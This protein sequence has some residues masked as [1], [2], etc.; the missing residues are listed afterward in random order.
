MRNVTLVVPPILSVARPSLGISAMKSALADVDCQTTVLYAALKYAELLGADINQQ[1][2]EQ[3]DHRLLV[4]DWIFSQC[5]ATAYHAERDDHYLSHVLAPKISPRLLDL[6]IAA[7]AQAMDFVNSSAQDICASQPRIVGI[8]S[9]FQQHCAALA[10]AKA[11]KRLKPDVTIC[12]GG[13]NCED[14]MGRATLDNFPYVDFVFSGES[15]RSFPKFVKDFFSRGHEPPADSRQ[16]RL[17]EPGYADPL[18]DLDELHIPDFSDYFEALRLASFGGRVNPALTFEASRGCWWGAKHH[19][20]FC[21]LNGGTMAFR[22][23]SSRR[24]LS[25]IE[26]LSTRWSVNAFSPSDNILAPRHIDEVFGQMPSDSELRFFYE[27][28]SNMS[29]EQILKIAK[30][31]VTWLQPGIESLCDHVLKL[32]NKGV[33]R[34]LNLRFLRSCLEIGVVPLWN[35]LVG[36]PGEQDWEYEEVTKLIPYIEHLNPPQNGPSFLRVD[37]FSPYFTQRAAV[38]FDSMRP[39]E[40][41]A[42]VYDLPPDQVERIAYFFAGQS[43]K[44]ISQPVHAQLAAAIVKWRERFWNQDNPPILASVPLGDSLLV[45][46]TRSIASVETALLSPVE[47][48]ILTNARSP[49]KLQTLIAK[50]GASSEIEKLL[51]LGYLIK[52]ADA[53]LSVVK[54]YG[55]E[56]RNSSELNEQ[57][58]GSLKPA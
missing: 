28:K 58:C 54:E 35:Y 27:I 40:A 18:L 49:L 44:L 41:Y 10:I 24:V 51:G 46:D 57:P 15:D 55:W 1:L 39:L 13:A 50:I 37:R 52:N 20:T 25:E 12:F 9:T 33:T 53:V 23:K 8:T 48:Q 5:I 47:A 3:T 17:V 29:H 31:G 56:V 42:Y 26:I 34:L 32:M 21:G 43:S 45:R 6:V 38:N 16:Q 14:E 11:I 22:A 7:R 36:F 30:G 4:G 19:C 2:A